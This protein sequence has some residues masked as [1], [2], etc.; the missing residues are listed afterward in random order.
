MDFHRS[1]YVFS[2]EPA[3]VGVIADHK[4][5]LML[6]LYNVTALLP[7]KY[8]KSSLPS[9]IYVHV[10]SGVNKN[11]DDTVIVLAV[12]D[13]IVRVCDNPELF[14]IV[15]YLCLTL[16]I[17]TVSNQSSYKVIVCVS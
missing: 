10:L 13:V 7:N 6:Y 15:I 5:A 17:L 11:A 3:A 16:L 8:N 1:K 4:L 2:T 9:I 14:F 12:L